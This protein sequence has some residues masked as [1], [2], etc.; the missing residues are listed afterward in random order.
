MYST[1]VYSDVAITR[2]SVLFMKHSAKETCYTAINGD[3]TTCR[4]AT[5][6][7]YVVVT[8]WSAS[9]TSMQRSQS[10]SIWWLDLDDH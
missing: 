1:Y 3:S 6:V 8:P 10:G 2:I 7:L 5:P 9:C 4:Q